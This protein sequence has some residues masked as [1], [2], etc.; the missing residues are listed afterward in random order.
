MKTIEERDRIGFKNSPNI[1]NVD[2]VFE[3]GI[4]LQKSPMT[5]ARY[6]AWLESQLENASQ[7]TIRYQEEQLS[8]I[9]E[10][11]GTKRAS[12]FLREQAE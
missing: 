12:M 4:W 10:I 1:D 6:I 11:L 8:G 2:T 3:V 9:Q 5:G 7:E